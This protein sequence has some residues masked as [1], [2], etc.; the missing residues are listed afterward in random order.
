MHH[1]FN[2]HL[3]ARDCKRHIVHRFDMP[4]GAGRVD[5]DLSFSPAG[6]HGL[7]NML[8][9][10]VFDSAGFRGAVHRGGANHHVSIGPAGATPGYVAGPLPAGEWVAQIDTHMI[11]PGHGV[12]YRLSVEIGP[13]TE[14]AQ[15][16][17]RQTGTRPRR[18]RGWYRGDLHSHTDHSDADSRGV[19]DLV[20]WARGYKLDFIFLTDHNTTS[21]LAEIEPLGGADLLTAGGLELTTFWGH[22]LC[23]GGRDWVDWRIQ[24]GG[25]Q[26]AS[27]AEHARSTQQLF[28]IAH[29]M[30]MGDP[31]CTGCSWRYGEMMPGNARAVEIWNG[32]WSGD[33]NNEPALA[34]WYDWLNQGLRMVATAGSDTHS[35][36]DYA[37]GPGFSVVGAEALTEAALLTAI[38]AGRLYLSSGPNVSFEVS[39]GERGRW[40]IGET[41]AAAARTFTAAASW[42][43]CP[44]G[45]HAHLLANGRLLDT[46]PADAA[47]RHEWRIAP[48]Q[49]DWMVIEI[50]A[51]GGAMLAITNPIFLSAA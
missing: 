33:S 17:R 26:M 40:G 39:D 14:L 34:L 25:G 10:T 45:A 21:G 43:G 19:A 44:P 41:V 11:M 36:S 32:P 6:E 48:G 50:R 30:S 2:G 5:I 46:R 49:A 37:E 27:I 7:S 9:L 24:P 3:T 8:T 47:G 1:Q 12:D 31:Q 23:L 28:V 42:A 18:G 29:P 38:R 20:A 35:N 16:A 13:A 22:A 4:P 51:A 15:P